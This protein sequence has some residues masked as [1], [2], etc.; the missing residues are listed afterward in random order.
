LLRLAIFNLVRN[1]DEHAYDKGPGVITVDVDRHGVRVL[2]AGPG[3]PPARLATLRR[4]LPIGRSKSGIGLALT[5]WIAEAH[6]GTLRLANRPEGGFSA[7]LELPCEPGPP[8][9]VFERLERRR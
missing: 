6:L 9:E 1:A 2:D 5:S 3:V 8:V 7:Q 4:D